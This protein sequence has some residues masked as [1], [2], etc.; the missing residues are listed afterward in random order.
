MIN[1]DATEIF[2][3][4]KLTDSKEFAIWKKNDSYDLIVVNENSLFNENERVIE[5]TRSLLIA[6]QHHHEKI[7]FDI[8]WMIMHNIVLEMPWL[9]KHNSDIDWVKKVLI[10]KQCN[11]MSYI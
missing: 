3:F 7:I 2:M 5:E 8:V 1:S 10:F 4:K 9:K 11:C 6:I